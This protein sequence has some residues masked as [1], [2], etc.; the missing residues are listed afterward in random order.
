MTCALIFVTLHPSHAASINVI[1]GGTLEVRGTIVRLW[2]IEVPGKDEVCT[3]SKGEVWAC[4]RRSLSQVR[5]IVR[6]EGAK[7]EMRE[8]GVVCHVA[9]LDLAALLVKEGLARS[10]GGYDEL[11]N[12]ARAARA[13]PW[14]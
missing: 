11:E 2:G 8:Q 6:Q 12:K 3:T 10:T 5:E 1:D 13:G 4:G 14:E 7:C 9:G